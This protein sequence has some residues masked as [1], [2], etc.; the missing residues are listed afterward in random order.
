MSAAARSL[1]VAVADGDLA[2]RELHRE[3]LTKLG[4]RVVA[5]AATGRDLVEQCHT[6]RAE[7]LVTA[8]RM[9]DMD[10]IEAAEAVNRES[11]TPVVLVSAFH[12][13]DLLER[14]LA[15]PIMAYLAKPVNEVELRA[16]ITLAIHRF[17]LFQRSRQEA[18]DLKQALEDRKLIER[19]KGILMRRVGVD[20]PE[21]YRRLRKLASD[22][23]RKLAEVARVVLTAEEVF[24]QME[25][26][27]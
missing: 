4:H 22:G 18:A 2:T 6:C 20:E 7:L 19:A 24:E 8:I 13:D 17:A 1:R 9:P 16:A 10:G 15:D 5:V 27:V 11:P 23:N 21:A 14:A 26:L 3:L 25:R 12:G